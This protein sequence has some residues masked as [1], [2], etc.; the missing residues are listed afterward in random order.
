MATRFCDG[1]TVI[2]DYACTVY[3][4]EV[5]YV[6]YFY[7]LLR[8]CTLYNDNGNKNKNDDDE[9]IFDMYRLVTKFT[10]NY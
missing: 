7:L 6:L 10:F 5:H 1:L 8:A 3:Y 9:Y 2:L 4:F